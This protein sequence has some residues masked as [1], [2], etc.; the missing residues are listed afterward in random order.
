M[1]MN[2][3]QNVPNFPIAKINTYPGKPSS[4]TALQRQSDTKYSKGSGDRLA[5][6]VEP[7]IPFEK[8]NLLDLYA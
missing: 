3:S 5:R 8:G 2:P 6:P 4:S 1:G 7:R